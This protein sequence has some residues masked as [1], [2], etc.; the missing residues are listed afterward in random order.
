MAWREE[1]NVGLL[2]Y[3]TLQANYGAGMAQYKS[4]S[5]T[6]VLGTLVSGTTAVHYTNDNQNFKSVFTT[7]SFTVDT[8]GAAALALGKKVYTF[9]AG[10]ILVT[11]SHLAIAATPSGA[12]LN[13]DQP[14]IGI[15]T[16]IGSGAVAN[17]TTPTTFDDLCVQQ[18]V[19]AAFSGA[20][21]KTATGVDGINTAI[22]SAGAHTVHINIA[23]TW[24][25]QDA[26]LAIAG[27]FTLLWSYM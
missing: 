25:G 26:A 16:V 5:G 4:A 6:N 13:T 10:N 8:V 14:Y 23:D 7:A 2:T 1:L 21:A 27:T 19:S 9:P 22:A 18:Q 3:D 12:T 17:L 24:A 15:G 11:G 20:V